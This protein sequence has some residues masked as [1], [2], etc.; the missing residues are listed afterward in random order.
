M[1]HHSINWTFLFPMLISKLPI[2]LI[3]IWY[4]FRIFID[5]VNLADFG[6]NVTFI[7]AISFSQRNKYI[8]NSEQIR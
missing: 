8:N 6:L 3:S 4:L 2:E 1:Q 5:L 7:R